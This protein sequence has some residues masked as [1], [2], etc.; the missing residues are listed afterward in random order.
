MRPSTCVSRFALFFVF[1]SLRLP[2]AFSSLG[3][4]FRLGGVAVPAPVSCCSCS[5]RRDGAGRPP[6]PRPQAH[7]R[8][9]SRHR[10]VPCLYFTTTRFPPPTSS[11]AL[12]P[13]VTYPL[14]RSLKVSIFS[15][16]L[17]DRR[18]LRICLTPTN[19]GVVLKT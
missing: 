12:R 19:N 4:R 2:R 6:D 9:G 16:P 18:Q 5:R 3:F 17:L 15:S 14:F 7:H 1:L 8:H 10:C 11:I 13:S